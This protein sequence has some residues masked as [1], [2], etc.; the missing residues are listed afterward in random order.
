MLRD[1]LIKNKKHECI[2]CDKKLPVYLLEAAH[3]KPYS[4]ITPRER[5]NYNIVEFMCLYC[6]NLY[7]RGFLGVHKGILEQSSLLD[8]SKFDIKYEKYKSVECYNMINNEFFDYHY[9]FIYKNKTK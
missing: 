4:I 6:H 5:L 7:D 3:L 2:L 8:L 1:Y 9:H